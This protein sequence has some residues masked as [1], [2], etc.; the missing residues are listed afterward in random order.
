MA[1]TYR[2]DVEVI[3]E[4]VRPGKQDIRLESTIYLHGGSH[5]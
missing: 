3:T 4:D 5:P 2:S 1:G